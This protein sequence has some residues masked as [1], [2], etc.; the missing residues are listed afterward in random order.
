MTDDSYDSYFC[1]LSVVLQKCKYISYNKIVYINLYILFY[2]RCLSRNIYPT[3]KL[4]VITVIC[5]HYR[6]F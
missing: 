4:T 1:A 6:G 3:G 2:Y 5:H